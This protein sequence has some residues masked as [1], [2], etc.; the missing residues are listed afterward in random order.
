MCHCKSFSLRATD[1]KLPV[2]AKHEGQGPK[3]Y[4]HVRKGYY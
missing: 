3:R 1:R 2:E 4:G